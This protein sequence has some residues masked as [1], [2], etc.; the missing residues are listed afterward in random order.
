MKQSVAK[1][2]SFT[3][4]RFNLFVYLSLFLAVVQQEFSKQK[5]QKLIKQ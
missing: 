3:Q 5:D 2:A 4:V 1:T